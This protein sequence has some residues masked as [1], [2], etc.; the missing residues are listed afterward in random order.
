MK[1]ENLKDYLYFG[2]SASAGIGVYIYCIISG[3]I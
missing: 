3:I 1:K 2:I